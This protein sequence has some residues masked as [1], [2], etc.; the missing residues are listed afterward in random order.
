MKRLGRRGVPSKKLERA[1]CKNIEPDA[2]FR[3]SRESYY[4][5]DFAGVLC[6]VDPDEAT[7]LKTSWYWHK[8]YMW[9]NGIELKTLILTPTGGS[10]PDV[11]KVTKPK[12]ENGQVRAAETTIRKN[13][14]KSYKPLNKPKPEEELKDKNQLLEAVNK[15]LHQKLMETQGEL[16]DLTQKVELLELQVSG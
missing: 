4:R 9:T 1:R 14:Q 11:S 8:T 6:F 12:R 3:K 10:D 7:V 15:R 2:R 16:K 13:I 5:V